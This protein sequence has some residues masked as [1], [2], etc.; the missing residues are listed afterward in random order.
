MKKHLIVGDEYIKKVDIQKIADDGTVIYEEIKRNYLPQ[1]AGKFLAIDTASGD[2]YLADSSADAVLAAKQR[3]PENVF[4]VVKI[5]HSSA[6]KFAKLR[7][8]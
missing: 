8:T 7:S 3:H 2:V 6:E 1:D 5:G 4:F